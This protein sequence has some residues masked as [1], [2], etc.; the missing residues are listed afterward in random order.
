MLSGCK[1]KNTQKTPFIQHSTRDS[2][3]LLFEA[4]QEYSH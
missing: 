4:D 1:I 3:Q 2:I